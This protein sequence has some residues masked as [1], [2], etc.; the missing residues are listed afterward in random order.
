[1][2]LSHSLKPDGILTGNAS[3]GDTAETVPEHAPAAAGG[4]AQQ[5]EGAAR[6]GRGGQEE[7]GG[8]TRH[9]AGTGTNTLS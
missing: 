8:T 7:P 5:P 1:M 2:A 6:D 3:G 4:R 9:H